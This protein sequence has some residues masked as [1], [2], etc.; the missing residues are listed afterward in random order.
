[1]ND[2]IQKCQHSA[3]ALQELAIHLER[4]RRFSEA[5][6]YYRQAFECCPAGERRAALE[7][8]IRKLQGNVK[9]T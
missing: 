2:S 9:Q 5:L 6:D 8:Q 4:E 7:R 1:M 3:A